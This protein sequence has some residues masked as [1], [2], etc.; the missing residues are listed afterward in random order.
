MIKLKLK[1]HKF[2]H[3]QAQGKLHDNTYFDH[4]NNITTKAITKNL[5]PHK[6]KARVYLLSSLEGRVFKCLSKCG[7]PRSGEAAGG[8]PYVVMGG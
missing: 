6:M 3:L 5:T 8:G 2:N 1:I 7:W 4:I